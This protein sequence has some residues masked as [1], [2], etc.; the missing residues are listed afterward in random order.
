[1]KHAASRTHTAIV[2]AISFASSVAYADD[3]Y[4]TEGDL[5]PLTFQVGLGFAARPH[6]RTAFDGTLRFGKIWG[7]GHR[8]YL[9]GFGELHT[10][11]FDT[12]EIS[13]GPQVQYAIADIT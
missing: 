11:G 3:D 2:L 10:V 8:S 7:V 5:D 1:M 4:S 12:A 6:H 13:F 9:G